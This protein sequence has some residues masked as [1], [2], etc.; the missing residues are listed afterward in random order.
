MANSLGIPRVLEP[1]DMVLLAVPDKLSVMTYLYQLRAYFTGQTLELQQVGTS[2]QESTYT[3]GEHDTD[4]DAR[5]SRE[6]YGR[7]I[8]EARKPKDSLTLPAGT[9]PPRSPSQEKVVSESELSPE[10]LKKPALMTRNQLL[11]PFDTDEE[12]EESKEYPPPKRE[13]NTSAPIQE[14]LTPDDSVHSPLSPALKMRPPKPTGYSYEAE[15]VW[16]KGDKPK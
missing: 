15:E 7:E 9:R 10:E 11:N 16:V 4:Q 8:A 3:V 5:I 12:D 2:A 13:L 14:V 6:M 1:S